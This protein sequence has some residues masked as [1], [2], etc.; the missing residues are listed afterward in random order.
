MVTSQRSAG[1]V[2]RLCPAAQRR[3]APP[4]ARAYLATG[5][6]EQCLV[7]RGGVQPVECRRTRSRRGGGERVS[8]REV[9]SDHGCR[10]Q[11]PP[12][13]G[14]TADGPRRWPPEVATAPSRTVTAV[15]SESGRCGSARPTVQPKPAGSPST[16]P[17][18]LRSPPASMPWCGTPCAVR[19][20]PTSRAAQPFTSPVGSKPPGSR[21]GSNQPRDSCSASAHSS[22]TSLTTVGQQLSVMTPCLSSDTWLPA[23]AV[24]KRRSIS[25]SSRTPATTASSA[26]TGSSPSRH[27]TSMVT[28][29]PS[30]GSTC[31]SPLIVP[32][33]SLPWR[34]AS[35]AEAGGVHGASD[36]PESASARA[37]RG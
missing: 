19:V 18:R 15:S 24:E 9:R 32:P 4:G 35:G 16:D 36:P 27:R 11:P 28:A 10:R 17:V 23:R 26:S 7:P 25:C 29:V 30:T 33:S 8:D 20:R 13:C 14:S 22:T 1:R 34:A 21:Q 31:T 6:H 37:R 2:R 5:Q 12:E 3:L